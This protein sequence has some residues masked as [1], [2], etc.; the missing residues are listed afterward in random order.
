MIS[1]DEDH[2][3]L[4]DLISRMLEYEPTHRITL[5]DALDHQF[6]CKLP[7]EY[8]LHEMDKYNKSESKNSLRERSHS[9]SR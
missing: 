1:E 8:R 4:F 9:L 5:T 2:R 7:L 6:F 3:Q